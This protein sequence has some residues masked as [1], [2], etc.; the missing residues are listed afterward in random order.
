MTRTGS[1]EPGKKH[2]QK[3]D[4]VRVA[5]GAHQ[6]A[7]PHELC[8]SLVDSGPWDLGSIQEEIVDL[9]GGADGSR[10]G[11]FLH[12]AVGSCADCGTSEPYVGEHERP[13]VCVTPKKF[14]HFCA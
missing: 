10:H 4:N 5:E 8:R 9:F 7:F 13:K 3:L 1:R 6:L 11:H 14:S 2:A 12:A